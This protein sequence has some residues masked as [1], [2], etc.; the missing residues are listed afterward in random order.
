M[1]KKV[2]KKRSRRVT[3]N[4]PICPKTGAPM[5]RDVRPMTLTYNGES[6]TVDMPGWYSDFSDTSVHTGQDILVYDH[7]LVQLKKGAKDE[8][9]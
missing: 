8:K 5:H 9:E 7:A 2:M 1:K 4:N 3:R 6:V